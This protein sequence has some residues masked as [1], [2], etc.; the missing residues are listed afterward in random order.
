MKLPWI[1]RSVPKSANWHCVIYFL[2]GKEWFRVRQ[3]WIAD[4]RVSGKCT[5]LWIRWKAVSLNL[6]N[7]LYG[8]WPRKMEDMLCS[9][10]S[11]L[12][13]R[14]DVGIAW[15]DWAQVVFSSSQISSVL[16]SEGPGKV[17]VK[18]VW[19]KSYLLWRIIWPGKKCNISKYIFS[20]LCFLPHFWKAFVHLMLWCSILCNKS[21]KRGCLLHSFTIVGLRCIS[22]LLLHS[23]SLLC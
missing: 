8:Y 22:P 12:S 20:R 2:T 13:W 19:S 21:W 3:C 14:K 15:L 7:I 4:L 16:V 17:F 18:Y 1:H 5:L 9:F 10:F 6:G 11:C 23:D